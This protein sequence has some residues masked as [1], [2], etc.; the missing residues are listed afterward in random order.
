MAITY[1]ID[2]L[3][4]TTESVDVEVAAKSEMVLQSTVTDPKTGAIVSTYVL[5][6]G[7]NSYPATIVYRSEIQSRPSGTIRRISVTFNTWSVRSDSVTGIDVRKPI[8]GTISFNTAADMTIEVAD[9]DSMVGNLFSFLYSAVT[10]G[11]RDTDWLADL[12]YG[13]PQVI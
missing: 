12:L 8:S 1:S 13:I 7:D 3:E 11:A 9:F 6:S 4:T 5:A 2:H 10:A